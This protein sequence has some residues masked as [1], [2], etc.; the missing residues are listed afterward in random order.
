MQTRPANKAKQQNALDKTE[1]FLQ[2]GDRPKIVKDAGIKNMLITDGPHLSATYDGPEHLDAG[3][4]KGKTD[5][6][7]H[8]AHV[9]DPDPTKGKLEPV[10]DPKFAN[11]Y[12]SVQ[13]A[14][15]TKGQQERIVHVPSPENPS[16]PAGG[17]PAGGSPAGGS[18]AGSPPPSGSS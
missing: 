11:R 7:S 17:S 15:P 2:T 5:P 16:T 4:Y 3:A 9:E 14:G 13:A 8:I 10:A 6:M 1:Q 18:P 12:P